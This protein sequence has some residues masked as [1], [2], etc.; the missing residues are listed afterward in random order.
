MK[1]SAKKALALREQHVGM[2][3]DTIGKKH[4]I[5][6]EARLLKAAAEEKKNQ[7]KITIVQDLR[8]YSGTCT[9]AD[10]VH[11]LF[12]IYRNH[13]TL[14]K[15]IRAEI[16]FQ[17]VLLE[18]KSS[19]LKVTGSVKKLVNQLLQFFVGEPLERLPAVQP[20]EQE[21]QANRGPCAEMDDLDPEESE[22]ESHPSDPRDQLTQYDFKELKY[23][24]ACR[25][26]LIAVYFEDD[27]FI[28][29]V[30]DDFPEKHP[31]EEAEVSFM[32]KATVGRAA[33]QKF[34]YRWPNIPEI[35]S[36]QSSVVFASNITLKP[37]S[38]S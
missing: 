34:V 30:E 32:I 35:H 38:S 14:R 24:F 20:D 13:T 5:S 7:Q 12:D 4:K 22:D 17:K 15:A 36:I 33:N 11:H 10:D 29:A 1:F 25:G 19:L 21:V 16:L 37:S 18:K 9:S 2:E 31:K 26:E 28:G 6:Q 23:K 8:P 27:F 3:K